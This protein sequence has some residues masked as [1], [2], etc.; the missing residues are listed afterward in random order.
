VSGG[1]KIGFLNCPAHVGR[2][3]HTQKPLSNPNRQPKQKDLA[4]IA[5]ILEAFPELQAQ[6]PPEI[7]SRLVA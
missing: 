1:K 2:A 5:R 3:E 6:V 7:Q 4:D